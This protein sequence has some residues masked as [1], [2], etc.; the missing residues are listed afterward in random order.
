MTRSNTKTLMVEDNQVNSIVTAAYLEKIYYQ[1]DI[2]V[3]GIDALASL[4]KSPAESPYGLILMDCIM[5]VMDGYE[6]TRQIRDGNAGERYREIPII[7]VTSDIKSGSEEKCRQAGMTDF[8]AKPVEPDL[9]YNKLKKWMANGDASKSTITE[10][11]L[12]TDSPVWEKEI[13]MNRLADQTSLFLR[14]IV[15]FLSDTQIRMQKLSNGLENNNMTSAQKSVHAI[16]S[17]SASMGGTRLQ[18]LAAQLEA[19]IKSSDY[20]SNSLQQQYTELVSAHSELIELLV[21]FQKQYQH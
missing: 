9:I 18:L 3:N 15:L 10:I 1:T 7:V 8:I 5:P 21:Q 19:C 20:D 11:S 12:Y 14:L 4:L 2:A 6:T 16:K 13:A 17:V